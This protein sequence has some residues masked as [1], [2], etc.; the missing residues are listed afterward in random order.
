M[1]EK[2]PNIDEFQN[3]DEPVN[4]DAVSD[5]G[6][7]PEDE[8]FQTKIKSQPGKDLPSLSGEAEI[9]PRSDYP[10]DDRY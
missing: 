6:E 8:D 4:A 5:P 3:E 9:K 2:Q 7:E 1:N 10:P